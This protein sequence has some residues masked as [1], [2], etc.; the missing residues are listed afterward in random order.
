MKSVEIDEG[1]IKDHQW[2]KPSEA[3]AKHSAGDI[4]LVPPTWITLHH[5]SL[6][7]KLDDV[8]GHFSK[9]TPKVYETRV[10]KASDGD[11]VAMWKGDSGYSDWDANVA[12]DRHRLVMSPGGFSF[13]NNVETY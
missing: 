8:L 4:D 13:E 11:R 3:L 2:I 7:E 5:L 9:A 12:G 10:V 6:Y 1:E